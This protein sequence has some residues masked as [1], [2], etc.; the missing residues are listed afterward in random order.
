MAECILVTHVLFETGNEDLKDL[1]K[2]VYVASGRFVAEQ[3]KPV[4]VEYKISE[5]TAG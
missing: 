2:K 5:V 1:E 3:G 4:A